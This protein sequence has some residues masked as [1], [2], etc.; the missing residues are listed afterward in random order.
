MPAIVPEIAAAPKLFLEGPAGAGKTTHCIERV[1]ALIAG[2]VPAS[3]ILL[4]TPHR[5]Y[6]RAYEDAFDQTTW[7][8]LG[9][10]TIGGLARRYVSLFWPHIQRRQK[11]PFPTATEP[12]FLTYEAAQYIMARLV[13]PLLE[14]GLFA[15]L[16]LTRHRLYSQLLDNLNKAAANGI[17][18]EELGR[19]LQ[20]AKISEGTGGGIQDVTRTLTTYRLYCAENN[21]VDFS[22]YLELFWELIRDEPTAGNHLF[23]TFTNLVYDN[24]E[25]DIPLAHDVIRVWMR[26]ER[27]ESAV[28]AYDVDAGF[29][30]FLAANPRSAYELSGECDRRV[31]L[32]EVPRVP[33]AL[34]EFG[35]VLI[36]A[37]ARG[38]AS[39]TRRRKTGDP[40]FHAYSDRLHHQMVERVAAKIV[41]L[42]SGKLAGDAAATEAGE[43]AVI[44]PFV[45]DTLYHGLSSRL[46][47][48]GVGFYLHRPSRS[49]RDDPVTRVLL[50][51]TALAHPGWNLERPHLEAV[52]HMFSRCLEPAD[53]V[54]AGLLANAS[55]R[56][57]NEGQG[58]EPFE[59]VPADMRE[60]ISYRVGEV[61]ERLR[62]WLIAYEQSDELPIDHFL[63]RLFGELLSQPGFGFHRDVQAGIQ[64]GNLVESARS[65]RRSIPQG[66]QR[67]RDVVG[68]GYVEM[69]QE[70]VISSFYG[71]GWSDPGDAVLIAPAHTFLLRGTPCA[72]QLW[73]DVGSTAWHRRIHQPLT[74][75][76]VLSR[77]WNIHEEWSASWEARYETERLTGIVNGLVR[78]CTGTVHLFASELSAHG[79][80]QRGELLS[81]LGQAL[82]QLAVET[83]QS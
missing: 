39:A 77:D 22:L 55:Y 6:A 13:S 19:Y 44:S 49:L 76:Y 3:E 54:R 60:R 63:S 52:A 32:D 5:S 61:Y 83:T 4:L 14:Q 67:E 25:E 59:K 10:A 64:V 62:N 57:L 21:L 72:Q 33:E 81:A 66:M 70:G 79:Q 71:S 29:R 65:F 75:P 45:S 17:P 78:R 23:G 82:G 80:E 69:V 68:R 15:D 27:L 56:V 58:L 47:E 18:P 16:K 53:L 28:V 36:D 24:C 40:H 50:T 48:A 9:K 43:I 2:A 46:D 73:L 30:R 7:H 8:A 11:Y 34:Q 38:P 35:H 37:V 51:L 41:E 20:A 42:A 12:T 26:D 31:R 74:N 1:R